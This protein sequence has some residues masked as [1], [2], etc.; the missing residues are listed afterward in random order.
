MHKQHIKSI[1][2]FFQ[3]LADAF[4][5]KNIPVDVFINE[6]LNKRK[7]AHLRRLKVEKMTELLQQ[8][9]QSQ[10]AAPSSGYN[11]WSGTSQ[12]ST[13]APYP[14]GNSYMPDPATYRPR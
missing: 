11:N 8:H 9:G 7:V 5:D 6:Y 14:V 2:F 4:C 13:N 10:S 1:Y 3:Q 12:M